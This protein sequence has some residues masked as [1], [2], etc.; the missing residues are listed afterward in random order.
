M[1][2]MIYDISRNETMGIGYDVGDESDLEKDDKPNTLQSHFVPSRKQNGGVL[3]GRIDS[4]SKAITKPH[5]RFN[6]AFMYRYPAQ[7][8]KFV[9]NSG[10]TNPKGPKMMWVPKD[11]ILYIVYILSSGV[12]TPVMVSVLWMLAT[13][14]G[15]KAYV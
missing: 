12:E 6:C 5:F 13:H 2:S 1:A 7:K 11:K 15:K 8:P 3:K 9:N 4:K 10:K 14:D